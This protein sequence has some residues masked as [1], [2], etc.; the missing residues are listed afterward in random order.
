MVTSNLLKTQFDDRVLKYWAIRIDKGHNSDDEIH[1]L[2]KTENHIYWTK[3]INNPD[4][5]QMCI[6]ISTFYFKIAQLYI[7]ILSALDPVYL[8]NG[9]EYPMFSSY[10]KKNIPT[11]GS[12]ISINGILH[13]KYEALRH[14]FEPEREMINPS[15]CNIHKNIHTILDIEGVKE[16]QNLYFDRWD[17]NGALNMSE[18]NQDLYRKDSMEFQNKFV[19]SNV[20]K[21]VSRFSDIHIYDTNVNPFCTDGTLK[22]PVYQNTQNTQLFADY[23]T[24][25]A[26]MA[27]YAKNIEY[28]LLNILNT[29]FIT[30]SENILKINPSINDEALDQLIDKTRTILVDMYVS[31]Q[32][33]YTNGIKI[34][35]NILKRENNMDESPFQILYGVNPDNIYTDTRLTP[36]QPIFFSK[37]LEDIE[38]QSPEMP[39]V[40]NSNS[41][42]M[43]EIV[44]KHENTRD[45][46]KDDNKQQKNQDRPDNQPKNQDRPDNQTRNQDRPD[47]QP[48][49]QQQQ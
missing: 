7:S 8:I 39:G 12:Q 34:Y 49:N 30:T 21:G 28:Q 4:K 14:R 18:K 10:I 47:N 41:S 42:T 33:F 45:S 15:Y 26:E 22:K 46:G 16:L 9:V 27:K 32:E 20:R 48:K 3:S 11:N 40:T 23:A 24:N 6:S 17:L 35:A 37:F 13:K 25:L 5:E 1:G 38:K 2:E 43:Q 19:P 29:I 31:G 36:G 44:T